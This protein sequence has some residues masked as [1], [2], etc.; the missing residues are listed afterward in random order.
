MLMTSRCF[1]C[2]LFPSSLSWLS[3]R[4]TNFNQASKAFIGNLNFICNWPWM[5][6]Q[7]NLT[8]LWWI[9]IRI[10][11]SSHVGF[12]WKS[13]RSNLFLNF[14]C[15][16]FITRCLTFY[17][18][19]FWVW[20]HCSLKNLQVTITKLSESRTESR[21]EFLCSLTQFVPRHALNKWLVPQSLRALS[22]E[23]VNI[24]KVCTMTSRWSQTHIRWSQMF[25]NFCFALF[26]R[27]IK[28]SERVPR[29]FM[30]SIVINSLQEFFFHFSILMNN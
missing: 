19:H 24:A 29:K 8:Q 28:V 4:Q 14:Y 9:C 13:D 1:V 10:D 18:F 5:R 17:V 30:C 2:L 25:I 12:K 11:I 16:K 15:G 6:S 22:R 20:P 23:H 27:F 7:M 3:H 21:I 26:C